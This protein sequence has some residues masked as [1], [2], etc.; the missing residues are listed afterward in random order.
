MGT[1]MVIVGAILLI[2][3]AGYLGLRSAKSSG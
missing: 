3:T 1:L 2:S